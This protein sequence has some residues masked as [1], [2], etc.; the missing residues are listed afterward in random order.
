MQTFTFTID[1]IK[2]IYQAGIKRGSDEATAFEW[3]SHASGK[4]YDECV[5]AIH[6]IVNADKNWGDPDYVDYSVVE[7]WF[8]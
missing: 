7:G 3:G 8:K 2:E 1:Q 4:Q 6:D 5:D